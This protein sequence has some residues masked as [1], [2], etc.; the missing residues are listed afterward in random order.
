MSLN[1]L[2]GKQLVRNCG[3][4]TRSYYKGWLTERLFLKK[5]KRGICCSGEEPVVMGDPSKLGLDTDEAIIK[6]CINLFII[7]GA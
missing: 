4:L 2:V 5:S 1:A 7:L 3:L 6:V